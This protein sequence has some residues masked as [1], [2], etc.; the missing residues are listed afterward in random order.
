MCLTQGYCRN[1]MRF[2]SYKGLSTVL[3]RYKW[4]SSESS[5]ISYCYYDYYFYYCFSL[6]R[7]CRHQQ[8]GWSWHYGSYTL[9]PKMKRVVGSLPAGFSHLWGWTEGSTHTWTWENYCPRWEVLWSTKAAL[10]VVLITSKP[11]VPYEAKGQD[12][13][14]WNWPQKPRPWGHWLQLLLEEESPSLG[15]KEDREEWNVSQRNSY[16][17]FE[18]KQ[19]E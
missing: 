19:G 15:W 1:K 7:M 8:V 5:H 13:C 6:H 11:G 12:V 2:I 17:F 16:Y 4:A 9:T 18:S 14:K 10:R 3:A